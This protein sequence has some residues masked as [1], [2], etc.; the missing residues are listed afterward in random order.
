MPSLILAVLSGVLLGAAF[1]P[2]PVGV[3][4]FIAFVPLIV[5]L[6]QRAMKMSRL[7]IIGALYVVFVIY[8][9]IT[10]WWICSWQ[11][12]TDPYLFA[13][14]LV[15]WLMHPLFLSLPFYVLA[16]I[17]RRLGRPWL[18]LFAPF[19]IT[20]FEWLHGQTE[21]SYPWLTTGYTLV[22]TPFVQ[23][24]EFVGVYGLT[25]LIVCV[26]VS[27]A[28][29]LLTRR[30][31]K[32][33]SMLAHRLLLALG[34]GMATWL[35]AGIYLQHQATSDLGRSDDGRSKS[36]DVAVVQP[37]EDPWDKW[38]DPREQVRVHVTM[39]DSIRALGFHPDLFLWSET[40]VP[41]TIRTSAYGQDWETLKRWVDTSA[42]SLLTGYADHYVYEH[43]EEPP[44]A[45]RS[46][47][48]PGMRYDIFNA[49]MVIN[50]NQDD[51]PVHRKTMLTPFAERLPFADKLTFAMS[52]I[53]WGVG[54]S[55]WGL[56]R[57]RKP[58][59]VVK[60]RE[61][62][63]DTVANMGTI[64]CI[65]SIYPEVARD[66]VINGA[67]VLCVI[68]NDAWYNGTW[69]P[70]QHYDIGRMRAV[71]Q[72]RTVVRCA[73]SGVSGFILPNGQSIEGDRSLHQARVASTI[74]PLTKGVAM[75]TIATSNEVTFY[76]RVGDVIPQIGLAASLLIAI[77]ARFSAVVRNM[78]VYTDQ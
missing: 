42:F 24:A 61:A 74:D 11:E 26:N 32:P 45:R 57:E 55:A 33:R 65:E 41:Y 72:R 12:K 37:N 67:D 30:A 22:Y 77:L 39:T 69:G 2:S 23:V 3:L 6:D 76:A 56:G 50:A 64:I 1:P 29:W 7:S 47:S 17:R 71:E 60:W 16:S 59:A 25:F 18:L 34:A 53:E 68:T 78:R 75:A 54:I 31:S 27:L 58:L 70:Q 8:H 51:V 19:T 40:A 20:G 10:N 35:A 43:G 28:F 63:I 49:A 62:G 38:S 14:G 48:S 4:S 36:I 46:Q 9:G 66:L 73:M 21:A 44:S 52:W 5:L 15:L 13:S